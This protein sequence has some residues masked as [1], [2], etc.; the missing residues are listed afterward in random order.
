LL[1]KRKL[2]VSLFFWETGAS[3]VGWDMGEASGK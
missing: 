2:W 1:K 3:W